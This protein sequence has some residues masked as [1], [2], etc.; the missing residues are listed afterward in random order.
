MKGR[1]MLFSMSIGSSL[2]RTEREEAEFPL[3]YALE[4]DFISL[5]YF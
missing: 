1:T 3:T 2:F 5:F 4:L